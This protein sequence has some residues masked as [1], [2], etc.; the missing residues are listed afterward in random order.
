MFKTLTKFFLLLA[1]VLAAFSSFAQPKSNSP[2]SRFGLGNL[3]TQYFSHINGM[4][5]IGSAYNSRYRLNLVNP[6]SYSPLTHTAFE[7]GMFAKVSGLKSNE[8]SENIW[9]GNLSYL[10]LGFPL[11]N[12][13]NDILDRKESK[14]DFGMTFALLPYTIVGYDVETLTP[15]PGADTVRTIF[16]GNGGTYRVLWGNSMKYKDFSFGVNLSYMFG[17]IS[18]DRRV[19]FLNLP[20]SYEDLLNDEISV[21]GLLWNVGVQYQKFFDFKEDGTAKQFSRFMKAGAYGNSANGFNTTTSSFY[22]RVNQEYNAVDTIRNVEEVEGKGKLPGEF[23]IGLIY[24]KRNKWQA[25]FDYSMSFW[26]QY[27]NDAKPENL[28][29]VYRIAMGGEIIPDINS[30]NNYW[31]KIRYRFGAFYSTDPRTDFLNKQLTNYGIT[32]GFGFPIVTRQKQS[33]VNVAFELGQF[34]SS[35]SL[36]ET[37]ARLA[38]GFTLNDASWFI[39]RKF[40]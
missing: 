24:G 25:G 1:F 21:G 27:E 7:V 4:A 29:N 36:R 18:N 37:Y 9:S 19:T 3:S 26:Q 35:E 20:A 11:R 6:A 10:A 16:Q 2:Y 40:N 33:F 22:L 15:Q 30:Y 32:F 5:N 12:P 13:I 34:G 38:L 8:Q 31:K 23:G 28:D 17:K 14:F 39:K